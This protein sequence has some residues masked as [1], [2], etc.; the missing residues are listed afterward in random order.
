MMKGGRTHSE[1]TEDIDLVGERTPTNKKQKNKNKKQK[2][3]G[4]LEARSRR[5]RREE[6]APS[7]SQICFL[8]TLFLEPM[9]S[10]GFF[11]S[12]DKIK[13]KFIKN[14]YTSFMLLTK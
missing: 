10:I 12:M 6:G 3:R 5:G 7:Y 8:N 4:R 9:K 14:L 11:N 1:E 13:I 2:G